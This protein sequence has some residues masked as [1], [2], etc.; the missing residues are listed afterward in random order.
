MNHIDWEPFVAAIK[1]CSH[2]KIVQI[3]N[4]K[5]NAEEE[6]LLFLADQL[7]LLTDET[8]SHDAAI[9]WVAAE[10][11]LPPELLMR[12]FYDEQVAMA[13]LFRSQRN[14]PSM[15]RGKR[16]PLSRLLA[17]L[18]GMRF[19]DED[20]WEKGKRSLLQF[21]NAV[22][23][24]FYRRVMPLIQ[25]ATTPQEAKKALL[26]ARGGKQASL[27]GSWDQPGMADTC[28]RIAN[29]GLGEF[30]VS[31]TG[32]RVTASP[33]VL[34]TFGLAV[35]TPR[36]RKAVGNIM[37]SFRKANIPVVH[38]RDI[39]IADRTYLD[40]V[41]RASSRIAAKF[42]EQLKESGNDAT[43]ITIRGIGD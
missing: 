33:E 17:V 20:S 37:A 15:K 31:P 14:L 38:F 30:E 34:Q 1:K 26:E 23:P 2:P 5:D 43:D 42:A 21:A 41:V 3:L 19:P 8:R 35:S 4:S 40:L 36:S 32:F 29:L 12:V 22:G 39:E 28:R 6:V 16:T 13:E 18:H 10:Y 27:T 7:D 11:L 25:L 9:E 24:A